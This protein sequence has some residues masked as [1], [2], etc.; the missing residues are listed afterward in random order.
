[1]E[2]GWTTMTESLSDSVFNQCC[3]WNRFKDICVTAVFFFQRME[4]SIVKSSPTLGRD[5]Q[6]IKSVSESL[7]V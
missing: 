1:M 6:Y 7:A 3:A 2:L 4:E 5:A